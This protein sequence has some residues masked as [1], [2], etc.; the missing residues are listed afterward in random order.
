MVN[1]LFYPYSGGTENHIIELSA[2]LVKLGVEVHVVTVRLPGTKPFETIRGIKVHRMPGKIVK[3]PGLYPP[4]MVISPRFSH[5]LKEIDTIENFDLFHLHDRW[6]LDFNA[7]V[8]YAHKTQR[9]CVVTIHN[10]RPVGI[11]PVF[12]IFGSAYEAA[13]GKKVLKNADKL[14]AVSKWTRDD[15]AK[16]DIPLSKFEVIYNGIN[17]EHFDSNYN[18]KIKEEIGIK[19]NDPLII[20]S[21]RIVEQKGLKYLIQAMPAIVLRYPNARLLIIGKGNLEKELKKLA[22][23]LKVAKNIIFYGEVPYTQLN[24]VLRGGDVFAFPSIWEPFGIAILDAMAS[25]LPVVA[26]RI[27]GIPEIVQNG[28]NGFLVDKKNPKQLANALLNVIENEKLRERMAHNA[29]TDAKT[30]FTWDKIAEQTLEVY[31]SLL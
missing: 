2:A 11:S 12:T 25:G 24:N 15:I 14:I 29:A 10:A 19:Q 28:R 30:K 18:L 1:A 7:A 13:I 20:W 26:A 6:Y 22:A 3:V 9:R 5:Y 23:K 16:Y 17:P 27:G 8:N 4:P 21:G 31:K